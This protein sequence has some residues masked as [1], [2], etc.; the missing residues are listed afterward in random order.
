MKTKT[1]TKELTNQNQ[2]FLFPCINYLSSFKV[3]QHTKIEIIFIIKSDEE[4]KKEK[5]LDVSE[6]QAPD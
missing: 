4:R 6:V 2:L 5:S 1:K 3:Y